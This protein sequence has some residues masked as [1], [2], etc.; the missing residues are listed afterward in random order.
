MLFTGAKIFPTNVTGFP[1]PADT[2]SS[3]CQ[4]LFYAAS[5]SVIVTVTMLVTLSSLLTMCSIPKYAGW[6]RKCTSTSL[7]EK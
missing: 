4:E 5:Y 6:F 1:L 7:C 2:I 3:T